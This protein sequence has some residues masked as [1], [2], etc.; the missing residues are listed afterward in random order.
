[1]PLYFN[2]IKQ[3]KAIFICCEGIG[4]IFNYD[5]SF[6]K[7]FSNLKLII[8]IRFTQFKLTLF[9]YFF[10]SGRVIETQDGSTI[11]FGF[12]LPT[13][14]PDSFKGTYGKIK[15]KFQVTIN[16]PWKFDERHEIPLNVRCSLDLNEN[17]IH[18]QPNQRQTTRNIGFFG[19]G[20]VSLH[21]FTPRSGCLIGGRIPLQVICAN[22]SSTPV[23]RV[24]FTLRQIVEYH[25]KKPIGY[26]RSECNRVMR[27]EAG[28]VEKKSEQQYEHVLE[29]PAELPATSCDTTIIR[30]RY[31]IQ[32]E[33]KLSGLFKNL[34]QTIPL[35]LGTVP[36]FEDLGE[37]P[38]TG[39]VSIGFVTPMPAAASPPNLAPMPMPMPYSG[40]TSLS[41]E[42]PAYPQHPALVPPPQ[43]NQLG[44]Y[45]SPFQR[46]SINNS[47][48]RSDSFA[49][50]P[51]A[52]PLD[53][54]SPNSTRSSICSQQ[55]WDTPPTYDQV[56]GGA[57][58][59]ASTP[60]R[61]VVPK[62]LTLQH[63]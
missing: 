59:A 14:L 51:S 41:S 19:G 36:F 22:H 17:A 62:R 13:H 39:N 27:K 52:P 21:V 48:V 42:A 6:V 47:S 54:G 23:E 10:H 45:Q 43:Y 15:Y 7:T 18:A 57:H 9:I 56:F 61:S 58:Q 29:I 24:K 8:S 33:A 25:S 35:T 53:F 38:L 16:R 46:H 63:F 55:V 26:K 2:L 34:V 11:P 20:P 44:S 5:I 37:P 30:F 32:V 31:E 12:P 1:M 60:P 4:T 50:S 49:A 40:N 3:I 28:G